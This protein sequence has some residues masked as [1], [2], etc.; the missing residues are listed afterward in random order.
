MKVKELL[1]RTMGMTKVKF[2]SY[3]AEKGEN[4]FMSSTRTCGEWRERGS[5]A[6]KDVKSID[7]YAYSDVMLIE[8]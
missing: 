3:N 2:F 7:I 6:D 5:H 8:I 1:D 4:E